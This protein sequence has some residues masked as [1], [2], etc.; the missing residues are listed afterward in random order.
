MTSPAPAVYLTKILQGLERYLW[1]MGIIACRR[2][3]WGKQLIWSR[4]PRLLRAG[5]LLMT[6]TSR[7]LE[8]TAPGIN[9]GGKFTLMIFT[10]EYRKKTCAE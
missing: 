6:R 10:L 1:S 5:L 4:I 2:K 8:F 7:T 3:Y 9:A